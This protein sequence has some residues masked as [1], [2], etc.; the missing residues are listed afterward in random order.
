[1]ANME[2]SREGLTVDGHD[3]RVFQ[4]MSRIYQKCCIMEN[5]PASTAWDYSVSLG[6]K[7]VFRQPLFRKRL[8]HSM[9]EIF[10]FLRNRIVRKYFQK[11]S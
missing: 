4:D 11:L 10:Q 3:E 8:L 1:M 5:I 6:K 7:K 9:L 2:A